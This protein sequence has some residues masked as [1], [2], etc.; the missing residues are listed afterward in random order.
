MLED[1]GWL[2]YGQCRKQE[3]RLPRSG[4]VQLWFAVNSTYIPLY[5][6]KIRF[7][8]SVSVHASCVKLTNLVSLT[9]LANRNIVGKHQVHRQ[10]V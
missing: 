4:L 6:V 8:T 10:E 3:R 1:V 7:V 9:Q 2:R 5:C